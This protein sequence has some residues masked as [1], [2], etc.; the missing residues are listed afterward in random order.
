M[1]KEAKRLKDMADLEKQIARELCKML[2]GI[3][4]IVEGTVRFEIHRAMKSAEM[5]A[6]ALVQLSMAADPPQPVRFD[7]KGNDWLSA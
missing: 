1:G 5:R 7:V 4:R 3:T 2:R 6:E